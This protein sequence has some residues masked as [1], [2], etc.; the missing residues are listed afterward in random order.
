LEIDGRGRGDSA[1][2][3]PSPI[4]RCMPKMSRLTSLLTDHS[5]TRQFCEGPL[6]GAWAHEAPPR[7]NLPP[8]RFG[9]YNRTCDSG[10]P[11]RAPSH[12]G[13]SR[14]LLRRARSPRALPD[15]SRCHRP[16][17]LPI[18]PLWSEPYRPAPCPALL[19]PIPELW[20]DPLPGYL[21]RTLNWKC[22]EGSWAAG[23]G[24]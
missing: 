12:L 2:S 18:A 16:V 15:S 8:P 5:P 17:Q 4:S 20:F 22:G 11:L 14:P 19:G 23:K 9:G 13:E 7:R 21:E 10:N 24:K 6:I 1:I 3:G